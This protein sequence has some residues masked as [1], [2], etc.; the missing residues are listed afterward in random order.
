MISRHTIHYFKIRKNYSWT[1]IFINLIL[2]KP[3]QTIHKLRDPQILLATTT[4]KNHFVS[5][6]L[7]AGDIEPEKNLFTNT[8]STSEI[9]FNCLVNPSTN[10]S[11][12]LTKHF[13]YIDIMF[14][15]E[16]EWQ[17]L[18]RSEQKR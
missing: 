6:P 3:I 11:Q 9:Q 5:L 8:H 14:N 16:S 17:R 13:I 7:G 2:L 1:L 4:F 15:D 18:V 12:P 10:S